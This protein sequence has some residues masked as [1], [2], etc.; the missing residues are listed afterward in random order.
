MNCVNYL[1]DDN[2]LI[3]IRS[4]ELDL[5]L[6]D[7][8]KVYENYNYTQFLTIGLPLAILILFGALFT[9]FRK[10]KYSR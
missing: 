3:S 8:E 1:L 10:R 7:K 4:K 9:Y 5:P 2:G 6:L